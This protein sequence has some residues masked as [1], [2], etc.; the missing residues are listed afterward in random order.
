MVGG[1]CLDID[2]LLKFATIPSLRGRRCN[3]CQGLA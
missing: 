3:G 2:N 1:K